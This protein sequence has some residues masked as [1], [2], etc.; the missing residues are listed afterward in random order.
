MA[1][2]LSDATRGREEDYE[3]I[4][5]QSNRIFTTEKDEDGNETYDNTYF[6]KL[7]PRLY[8]PKVNTA[9]DHYIVKDNDS[10]K[11]VGLV[12]APRCNYVVGD[13]KVVVAGIGTVGT[14]RDYRGSGVMQK[15][16]GKAMDDCIADG[17]DFSCL[18]GQRQRYEYFGFTISGL[19]VMYQF[20][21]G[22]ARRIYGR[23][24][25]FGYT[26]RRVNADDDDLLDLISDM[27]NSQPV[28]T[29]RDRSVLF[30]LLS[31]WEKKPVAVYSGN[32]FYGYIVCG[33]DGLHIP[34]FYLK[35]YDHTG[36]VFYDY[37]R[38]N[39]LDHV[40]FLHVSL[41]E[42]GKNDFLT[43]CCEE[44][45]L[46]R[47]ENIRIFRFDHM[48]EV[49]LKLKATYQ[50]LSDGRLTIH[51]KDQFTDQ[52]FTVECCDQ[53]VRAYMS[54]EKPD[55]ESDSL[56][57]T[58]FMF[59]IGGYLSDFGLDWPAFAYQWFPLP[60]GFPDTDCV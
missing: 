10:G 25:D 2:N 19:G 17:V 49:F 5:D 45:D 53:K 6:Q 44:I 13:D 26:F 23:D 42:K 18:G 22:N 54:D 60:L 56:S 1:F 34:E 51:V 7:H 4:I 58:Q 11:I 40:T 55:I 47:H 9:N 8:G 37:L 52:N 38:A 20:H 35:D 32:E 29:E 39:D 48:T 28:H 15:F 43:A 24:R 41:H 21:E 3:E 57:L 14:D 31:A 33:E 59:G 16:L 50:K 36:E 27:Y 30:E 46:I 12:V